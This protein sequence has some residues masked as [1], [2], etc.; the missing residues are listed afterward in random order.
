MLTSQAQR[1]HAQIRNTKHSGDKDARA[2]STLNFRL[3]S[4]GEELCLDDNWQLW[5]LAL[6]T[7]FEESLLGHVKHRGLLLLFQL[8]CFFHRT[9]GQHG[10]QHV[11]VNNRTEAPV[12]ELVI[13]SHAD[14]TKVARVKLVHKDTMM[15]LATR[16]T[17]AARV[18]AVLA[19]PAV[20]G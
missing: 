3:C 4:L 20:S 12:L 16:V 7:D 11:Q 18:L 1:Y 2:A 9:L 6:A 10:P 8:L 14:L 13:L 17:A 15:V 5:K 19:D